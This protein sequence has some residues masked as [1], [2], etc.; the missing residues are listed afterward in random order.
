MIIARLVTE[1]RCYLPER[2]Q[3]TWARLRHL[4]ARRA[5]LVTDTTAARQQVTDLLEC[6][7]RPRWRPPPSP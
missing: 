6:A 5:A 1:L 4:G 7:G 3:P 2:A